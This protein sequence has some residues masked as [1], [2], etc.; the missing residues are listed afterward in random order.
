[1]ELD[2]S[3]VPVLGASARPVQGLSQEGPFPGKLSQVTV[4]VVCLH[5]SYDVS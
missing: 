4:T 2:E 1:M 5:D 3:R